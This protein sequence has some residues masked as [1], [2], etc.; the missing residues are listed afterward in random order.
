MVDDIIRLRDVVQVEL[1][2]LEEYGEAAEEFF[3]TLSGDIRREFTGALEGLLTH[4]LAAFQSQVSRS[5]AQSGMGDVGN[6]LGGVL[7]NA[8]DAFLPENV[9]GDVF[10]AAIGGALRSAA[11]DLS[12]HGSLDIGRAVSS[13]NRAGGNRLDA[14]IHHGDLPMSS[15][16]RSAAAWSELSHGRRNL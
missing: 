16:Q 7:G 15:S 5:L 14:V 8:L 13:A 11:R 3:H 1:E 9:F 4:D 12:R 2:Q 10:G 6:A